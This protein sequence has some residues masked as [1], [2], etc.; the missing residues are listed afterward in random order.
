MLMPG[1]SR[2]STPY[3]RTSLPMAPPT[4]STSD[5]FQVE[6]REVPIGNLVHGRSSILTPAGPSA[7]TIAGMPSLSIGWVVPAEPFT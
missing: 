7:S 5:G 1:A 6:A 4:S 2:T 3:S